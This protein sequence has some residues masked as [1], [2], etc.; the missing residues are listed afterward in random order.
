MTKL[1]NSRTGIGKQAIIIKIKTAKAVRFDT[2][3]DEI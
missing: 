1:A 2:S 3:T